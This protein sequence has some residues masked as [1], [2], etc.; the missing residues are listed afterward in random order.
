MMLLMMLLMIFSTCTGHILY[1]GKIFPTIS[2]NVT[3]LKLY[4]LINNL[5]IQDD[6]MGYAHRSFA[7]CGAM[8]FVNDQTFTYSHQFRYRSIRGECRKHHHIHCVQ[9]LSRMIHSTIQWNID[10]VDH[11]LLGHGQRIRESSQGL[12]LSHAISLC[13]RDQRYLQF[14]WRRL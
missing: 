11:N 5:Q 2:S 3:D 4:G 1:L 9:N 10:K 6:S 8:Q 12:V 14:I 7:M 13:I